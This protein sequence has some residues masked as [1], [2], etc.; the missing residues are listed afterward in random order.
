MTPEMWQQLA[1][2]LIAAAAIYGGI[3]ADLKWLKS[4]VERLHERIDDHIEGHK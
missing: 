1:F 3:R 2:S 4:S